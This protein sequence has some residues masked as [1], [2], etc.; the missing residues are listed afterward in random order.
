MGT[1]TPDTSPCAPV[2]EVFASI[3][4][5]A[6]FVGEPQV[7]LRLRGCPLRCR[8]CDT[9]ASWALAEGASARIATPT[10]ARREDAWATPFQA[11]C[12]IAEVEPGGPRTVSVTGGEPLLWPEFVLALKPM[13]GR[14]RLHLETAGAHPRSLA[15]VLPACDHVSLDLKPEFDL[16]APV[17]LAD[18]RTT[19]ERAPRDAAE[20]SAA[21]REC[22]RLVAGRDACGKLVVA[23]SRT[24]E[25][26]APLLDEVEREASGLLVVVQPASPIG[27]VEAPSRELVDAVA[28]MARDRELA[29]RVLPQVHRLLGIP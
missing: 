16:D 10:R 25:A 7:F 9:P 6:A 21:R 11:A 12:W 13:L 14:R 22:L 19:R 20:W 29:V 27:G 4:G 15:R 2:L 28:E 5:E 18:P 3:Q 17:E 1:S 24:P 23:G 26:Y 8:W